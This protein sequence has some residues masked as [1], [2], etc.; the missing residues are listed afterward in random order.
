MFKKGDIVVCI[1]KGY[2]VTKENDIYKLEV[3]ETN[4][5]N[6]HG[7]TGNKGNNN[8]SST[9]IRIATQQEINAY[10]KGITNINDIKNNIIYEIY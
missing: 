8:F 3:N 4:Y 5:G 7:K 9:S 1:S 10:N 6:V 2:N